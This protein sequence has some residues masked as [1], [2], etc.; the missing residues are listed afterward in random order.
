MYVSTTI[1]NL[2]GNGYCIAVKSKATGAIT[3][4]SVDLEEAI[5]VP[6][7]SNAFDELTEV[8]NFLKTS[9]LDLRTVERQIKFRMIDE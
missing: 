6:T 1:K 8:F 3:V 9:E 5:T 7:A 4:S 2:A